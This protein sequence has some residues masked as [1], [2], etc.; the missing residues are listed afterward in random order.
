[1]DVVFAFTNRMTDVALNYLVRVDLTDYLPFLVTK[2]A[3]Y[4]DLLT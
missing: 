4:F 3:P 1:V 2:M